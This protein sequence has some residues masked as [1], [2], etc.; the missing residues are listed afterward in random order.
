MLNS[1]Y[2][3]NY[4]K[5]RKKRTDLF[6]LYLCGVLRWNEICHVKLCKD[7]HRK[8]WSSSRLWTSIN[9]PPSFSFPFVCLTGI[10]SCSYKKHMPPCM[11]D[12]ILKLCWRVLTR[13]V[14]SISSPS[15]R[16]RSKQFGKKYGKRGWILNTYSIVCRYKQQGNDY[17]EW[18]THLLLAICVNNRMTGEQ[19]TWCWE[20]LHDLNVS[21]P[22]SFW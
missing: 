19:L 10:W 3:F 5:D 11:C 18:A 4:A 20:Q 2:W 7:S 15:T 9:L 22:E 17:I 8:T 12:S 1:L 21:G 16:M 13:P 14:K 6:L